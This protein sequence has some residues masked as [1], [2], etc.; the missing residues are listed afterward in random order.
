MDTTNI[1]LTLENANLK[2]MVE[3]VEMLNNAI[4]AKCIDCGCL[5]AEKYLRME[6]YCKTCTLY[7]FKEK[8]VLI[9]YSGI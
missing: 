7:K 1:R 5:I 2:Q 6:I 3:M 8:E 9:E 4:Q